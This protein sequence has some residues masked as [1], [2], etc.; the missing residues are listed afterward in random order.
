MVSIS[1]IFLH[2]ILMVRRMIALTPIGILL[3]LPRFDN[4]AQA[5]A[6]WLKSA[7]K[8]LHSGVGFI[9]IGPDCGGST[10]FL[11]AGSVSPGIVP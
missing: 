9:A 3:Y 4:I 10:S 1:G 6:I 5:I 8:P 2:K 11:A 7:P